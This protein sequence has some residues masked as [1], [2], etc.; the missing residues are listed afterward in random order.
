MTF[1]QMNEAEKVGTALGDAFNELWRLSITSPQGAVHG[2][3][4][5]RLSAIQACIKAADTAMDRLL[6]LKATSV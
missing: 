3:D 5:G 2:S 4:R 1:E 6:K